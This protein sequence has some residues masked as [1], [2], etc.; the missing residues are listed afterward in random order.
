[1][2]CSMER[3]CALSFLFLFVSFVCESSIVYAYLLYVCLCFIVLCLT[4]S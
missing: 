3:L 4:L 2:L 1:M